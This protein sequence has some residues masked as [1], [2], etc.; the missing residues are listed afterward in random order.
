MVFVRGIRNN[1]K[2][3]HLQSEKLMETTIL[4]LLVA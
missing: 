3:V 2:Q 1:L 4:E